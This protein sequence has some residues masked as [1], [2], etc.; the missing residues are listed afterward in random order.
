MLEQWFSNFFEISTLRSPKIFSITHDS[1]FLSINFRAKS[2]KVKK[3]RSLCL[4]MSKQAQFNGMMNHQK[5][6]NPRPLC[7][8]PDTVSQT[9]R[10]CDPHF[11]N[12][13]VRESLW[14]ANS[15]TKRKYFFLYLEKEFNRMSEILDAFQRPI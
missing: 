7:S 8:P 3:K 1:L 4:Q 6:A 14:T 12:H 2:S 10:G 15:S 9:P 11:E 13:T 5:F